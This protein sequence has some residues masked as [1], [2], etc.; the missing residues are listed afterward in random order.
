MS[1][2]QPFHVKLKEQM[3]HGR[4]RKDK[5][6]RDL[7]VC[8]TELSAQSSTLSKIEKDLKEV[9]KAKARFEREVELGA[10]ANLE[11]SDEFISEYAICLW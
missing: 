2:L 4:K 6:E 7:A 1:E 8:K 11:L 5:A 10:S 9:E 3:E